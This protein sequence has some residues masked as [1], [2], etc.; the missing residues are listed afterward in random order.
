MISL[1]VEVQIDIFKFLSYEE[2]YPIK[3]TNLYFRD[4]I[5]NFEGDVPREKFYKI[6]IGDIDRFKRDPRKLIRPNSEHFYIPLSEQ[7]EE[8]LN[9]EL[10]TPIPLYL[11]DQNL[12][13][14]NIVI[15]LSK[16]VYGIESQHLLQLPIFIKNKNEIKTVYYYLN[17]LFNCFFEYSCFGKFILNT[18]LINLLFGNAKHF[19]IQT[20][21]LSITDNN[22]RNLFKFSL[23][24]LVSELLIINFFICEA[25]IEEYKDILLKIITSGGDNIE[26]IY[27]SFS[28]LEGMNHDINV[29]LLFDRI[30]EYVATSRDCSKNC[31]YY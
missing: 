5:N 25:D 1:P 13:N 14:K 4:F 24:R 18:Q 30:V 21:N 3:L 22:I 9:N 7:L 31:T 12:D 10:E 8:K 27:L 2:L 28:I 15:C 6:S 16:K 20:C 29:S 23:K 19:Y 26:H 17:K 11:P